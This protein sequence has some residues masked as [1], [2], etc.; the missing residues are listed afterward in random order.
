VLPPAAATTIL[1][2]T[3]REQPQRDE[4]ERQEEDVAARGDEDDHSDSDPYP[5]CSEHP[6]SALSGD[7]ACPPLLS[8]F[9]EAT[10]HGQGKPAQER[11]PDTEEPEQA[12]QSHP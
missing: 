2:L 12:E 8:L 1:P 6:R 10:D 3:K 5:K 7:V 9:Q 11:S 4:Q